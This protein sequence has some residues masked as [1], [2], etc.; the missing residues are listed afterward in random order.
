VPAQVIGIEFQGLTSLLAIISSSPFPFPGQAGRVFV[1]A[2]AVE[3][4][5]GAA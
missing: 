2:L 1:H 4:A 5:D 3:A